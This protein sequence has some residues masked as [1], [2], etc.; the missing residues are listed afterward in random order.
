M[1]AVIRVASA[2]V[3][4]WTVHLESEQ[5]CPSN[6]VAATLPCPAHSVN[7]PPRPTRYYVAQGFCVRSVPT[8]LSRKDPGTFH[9]IFSLDNLVTTMIPS[10]RMT[11]RSNP[12]THSLA[13]RFRPPPRQIL[14]ATPR[15]RIRPKPSCFNRLIFSNRN[16]KTPS[17]RVLTY[18]LLFAFP[19]PAKVAIRRRMAI[20]NESAMADESKGPTRQ[21]R[22]SRVSQAKVPCTISPRKV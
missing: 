12:A 9:P 13:N 15:N 11:N 8:F 16:K 17:P 22:P 4:V 19:S 14:I 18:N 7:H 10:A 3:K 1:V 5:P 6:E 20:L 2:S 21:G